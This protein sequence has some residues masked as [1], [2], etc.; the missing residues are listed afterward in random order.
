MIPLDQHVGIDV[1]IN[2]LSLVN[3]LDG[4][5]TANKHDMVS[6]FHNSNK[7]KKTPLYTAE[8]FGFYMAQTH[9][10]LLCR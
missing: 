8:A 4:K 3:F 5:I 9:A 10:S 6:V 2:P 7:N 1:M